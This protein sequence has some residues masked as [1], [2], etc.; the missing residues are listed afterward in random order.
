[1]NSMKVIGALIGSVLEPRLRAESTWVDLVAAAVVA[2]AFFAGAFLAA[3]FLAGAFLGAGGGEVGTGIGS[4][5]A[6]L[7]LDRPRRR[8]EEAPPPPA[9]VLVRA[10]F[11]DRRLAGPLTGVRGRNTQPTCSTGLP[12]M[13]RPSSNSH[14]YW[15]WNSW[16]E[17]FDSTVA[18]A[19]SAMSRTNASPRPIAPAGGDTSSPAS[20]ASS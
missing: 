6:A 9:P 13:S 15:P 19:L 16:K 14:P 11:I 2:G 12:P 7:A 4:L 18:S 20:T 17:S 3:A 1:M 5:A 8:P 10:S